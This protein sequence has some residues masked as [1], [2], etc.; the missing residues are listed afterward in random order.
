MILPMTIDIWCC[1]KPSSDQ[2]SRVVTTKDALHLT[3]A[4]PSLLRLTDRSGGSAKPLTGHFI[5][6]WDLDQEEKSLESFNSLFLRWIEN[7]C[8][9]Q[10]RRPWTAKR[11]VSVSNHPFNHELS[12]IVVE[13]MGTAASDGFETLR[14]GFGVSVNT[15]DE[16]SPV[17]GPAHSSRRTCSPL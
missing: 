15:A 5:P 14:N 6:P 3:M 4:R 2:I 13:G 8:V 1:L 12:R 11:H 16:L 17:A 7:T 10:H 9:G